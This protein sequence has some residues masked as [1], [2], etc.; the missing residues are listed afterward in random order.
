MPREPDNMSKPRHYKDLL[1]WQKG[2][3]LAKDIY[4][5]TAGF[6]AE[7]KFGLTSQLRR[8]AVSIS[9]NIAEGQAR[10]GTKEFASFLAHASGSLAELETQPLLSIDLDYAKPLHVAA[11]QAEIGEMQK[12]IAAIQQKLSARLAD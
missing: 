3:H 8:A 9:S 4:Q 6:P 5:L 12:M 7:E 1:I 11:M 2:M 10:R